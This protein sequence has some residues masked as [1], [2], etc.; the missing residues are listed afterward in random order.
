MRV[1]A[2]G[3][4]IAISLEVEQDTGTLIDAA[5]NSFK[6]D[7]DFAVAEIVYVFGDGIR[8]VSI[9]L[10]RCAASWFGPVL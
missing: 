4:I 2:H 3:Q 5:G 1:G 6:P 7:G 8:K 10:R 9:G